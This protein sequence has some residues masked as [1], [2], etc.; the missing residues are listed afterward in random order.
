MSKTIELIGSRTSLVEGSESL[1]A[2]LTE[3]S[4]RKDKDVD[5]IA[6]ITEELNVNTD[7]LKDVETQ[8]TASL[9]PTDEADDRPVILEVRA[10]TG[11]DE[12]SLFAQRY[13]KCMKGSL[14]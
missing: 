9:I 14:R 6:L 10:G 2:M 7:K 1:K 4:A 8:I 13:S 11:G 5:L 3:E 12:A